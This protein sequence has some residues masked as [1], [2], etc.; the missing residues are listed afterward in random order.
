MGRAARGVEGTPSAISTKSPQNLKVWAIEGVGGEGGKA[1]G[2][3]EGEPGGSE[4]SATGKTV[5]FWFLMLRIPAKAGDFLPPTSPAFLSPSF[6]PSLFPLTPSPPLPS[7][8]PFP[9][10]FP[11]YPSPPKL[12]GGGEGRGRKGAR[13]LSVEQENGGCSAFWMS[14][15]RDELEW[16]GWRK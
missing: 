2:R 16:R 14:G 8:T 11:P 4:S 7:P 15:E 13:V 3:L 5:L 6:P 10:P 12:C 9:P 1:G